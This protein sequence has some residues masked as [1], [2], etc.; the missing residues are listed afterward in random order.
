[1]NFAAA[2]NKK[3]NSVAIATCFLDIKLFSIHYYPIWLSY[4]YQLIHTQTLKS[5]LNLLLLSSLDIF[6]ISNFRASD[7]GFD[8]V[9]GI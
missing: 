5:N 7:A 8:L 3:E 9:E 2:S 1:M 4:C 6:G